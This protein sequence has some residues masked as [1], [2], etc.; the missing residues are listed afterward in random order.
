MGPRPFCSFYARKGA[1]VVKDKREHLALYSG[2]CKNCK[3]LDPAE[4]KAYTLCH[5]SK[6]NE[7]CP[8][9]EIQIVVV[10]AAYRMAKQVIAA[11][12]ARNAKEEARILARVAKESQA[13]Q[14]RFYS[15]IEHPTTESN[16]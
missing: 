16:K 4:T 1:A 6:G 2:N 15:A 7:H 14:E 12:D 3:H 10:G 8:A 11:R 5:F 9:S 13:F